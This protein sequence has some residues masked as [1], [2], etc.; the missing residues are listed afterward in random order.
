MQC[1]R[2][3]EIRFLALGLK[4]SGK[5]A[6]APVSSQRRRSGSRRSAASVYEFGVGAQQVVERR[7]FRGTE[8]VSAGDILRETA[9]PVDV[10]I[11]EQ[12]APRSVIE[13]AKLDLGVA[14]R[15]QQRER[16]PWMRTGEQQR[17]TQADGFGLDHLLQLAE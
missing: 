11:V 1:F 9:E 14:A 6:R 5:R 4:H 12:A 10:Q 17:R 13:L 16:P 3:Y 8:P 15:L 7:N 2:Q